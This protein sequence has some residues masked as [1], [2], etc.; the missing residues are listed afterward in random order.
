MGAGCIRKGPSE[1]WPSIRA[2]ESFLKL[3]ERQKVLST[4]LG[5]EA[6]FEV[7]LRTLDTDALVK[8]LIDAKVVSDRFDFFKEQIDRI[9]TGGVQELL[10]VRRPG[11]EAFLSKLQEFEKQLEESRQVMVEGKLIASI[12]QRT[13]PAVLTAQQIYKIIN[14]DLFAA[15]VVGSYVSKQA[16]GTL[17]W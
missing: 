5:A 9:K 17:G 2:A 7:A 4:Q 13:L 1:H 12:D 6:G 11:M 16:R 15:C 10:D 3:T 8:K 14:D